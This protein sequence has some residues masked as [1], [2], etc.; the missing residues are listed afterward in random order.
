MATI[1]KPIQGILNI[2]NIQGNYRK[3]KLIFNTSGV[4]IDLR[5]YE[6][7]MQIKESLNT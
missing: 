6:I 4:P 7:K 5:E 1:N 3:I 2:E